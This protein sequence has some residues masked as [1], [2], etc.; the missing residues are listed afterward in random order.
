M[1]IEG[2]DGSGKST[3]LARLIGRL[4][5]EKADFRHIVFPQYAQP[6]SSLVRMYLG[7]EFGSRPG[8]VNAYAASTFFAVDRYAS[9]KKEWQGYYQDGGFVLA[10]RYTTAN[11]VHQSAKLPV[12][13]REAFCRWLFHFEYTLM[14]L[15]EP[16]LVLLLDMPTECSAA[17]I[18]KRHTQNDIHEQDIE[19]LRQCRSAAQLAASLFGWHTVHCAPDNIL[20]TVEDIHEEIYQTIKKI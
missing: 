8:D 19:Y 10:D 12:C 18:Q 15:P 3:Q 7:G 13:E 17:L 20:R 2:T 5:E 1:V 14:G 4:E 11:A 16:D 6:S 9:Y